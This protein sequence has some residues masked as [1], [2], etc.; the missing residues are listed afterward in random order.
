MK[1]SDQRTANQVRSISLESSALSTANG[2]CRYIAGNT[3]LLATVHGPTTPLQQRDEDA[4]KAT[5]SVQFRPVTGQLTSFHT[6]LIQHIKQTFNEV[7]LLQAYPRAAIR[8]SVQ[9]VYA[10]GSILSACINALMYALL[11]AG[12]QCKYITASVTLNM[13]AAATTKDSEA[14]AKTAYLFDPTADEESNSSTTLTIAAVPIPSYSTQISDLQLITS[15]TTGQPTTATDYMYCLKVGKIA[16]RHLIEFIKQS[17][18]KRFT[19]LLDELQK[20]T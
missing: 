14:D 15:Y 20:K 2:S 9:V 16:V 19:H 6:D 11:D 4:E 8:L 5:L 18:A 13:P 1:R 3:H 10:D 7:I 17:H 12:I